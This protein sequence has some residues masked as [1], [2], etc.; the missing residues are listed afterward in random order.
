M[1]KLATVHPI[2]LAALRRASVEPLTW[3]NRRPPGKL[4]R[5]ARALLRELDALDAPRRAPSMRRPP[6]PRRCQR[7]ADESQS[8]LDFGE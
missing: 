1:P 6:R 4:S 2:G 8:L 7:R 5:E 3:P